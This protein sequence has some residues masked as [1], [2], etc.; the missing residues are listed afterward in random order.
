MGYTVFK[1]SKWE[2]EILEYRGKMLERAKYFQDIVKNRNQVL[3]RT[4]KSRLDTMIRATQGELVEFRAEWKRLSD[5]SKGPTRRYLDVLE[6]EHAERSLHIEK[7]KKEYDV[8]VKVAK[9]EYDKLFKEAFSDNNYFG[10]F[11]QLAGHIQEALEQ[12]QKA[13]KAMK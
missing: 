7:M 12:L 10:N 13:R 5:T 8:A 4:D 2:K 9:D 3:E 1:G 6:R 11:G